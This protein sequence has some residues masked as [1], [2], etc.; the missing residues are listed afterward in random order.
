MA[1]SYNPVCTNPPNWIGGTEQ[2]RLADS[3]TATRSKPAA[4]PQF[5]GIVQTHSN[6]S[7]D[8][9]SLES[10][11][12]HSTNGTAKKRKAQSAPVWA[13]PAS[14]DT[15]EFQAAWAEW[16]AYRRTTKRKPMS[17]VAGNRLLSRMA[18]WGSDRAVDAIGFSI[19]NDYQGIFENSSS[20]R[21]DGRAVATASLPTLPVMNIDLGQYSLEGAL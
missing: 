9:S 4:E 19:A 17:Q 16:E 18:E 3:H 20:K 6:N 1:E 2:T 13:I 11:K 8:L 14:L 10:N 5:G 21:S 7:I 12:D 15:P